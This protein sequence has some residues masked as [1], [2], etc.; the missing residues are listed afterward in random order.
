[1]QPPESA[2][3]GF[4]TLPHPSMT[5]PKLRLTQ[6]LA[7]FLSMGSA[8][9]PALSPA[10]ALTQEGLAGLPDLPSAHTLK[11]GEMSFSLSAQGHA[12]QGLIRDS[13]F[14]FHLPGDPAP[15]S[16]SITDVQSYGL[17]VN[18]AF[19]LFG[20]VDLGFSL[21]VHGD[22]TSDTQAK[23]LSGQGLGDP[24]IFLKTGVGGPNPGAFDI[25]ALFQGHFAS[26]AKAGFLPKD[27]GFVRFDSNSLETRT[28]SAGGPWGEAGLLSTLNLNRLENPIPLAFHLGASYRALPA[29][30]QSAG[31]K[32]QA[33]LEVAATPNLTFFAAG[34]TMTRLNRLKGIQ[35]LADEWATLTGGISVRSDEGFMLDVGVRKG[36]AKA[37]WAPYGKAKDGGVY[38]Y[39]AKAQPSWSLSVQFG[40]TFAAF[41]TDRDRDGVPDRLD[42]CAD[43]AEDHDG[44]QDTDGCPEPDNDFDSISDLQDQ[45][46]LQAED[47]EGFKDEDGCPDPDNDQDGVLDVDDKCP[48]DAEDRDGFVDFDGCPELDNDEDGVHDNR[49]QCPAQ[50]EDKDGHQDEDGCPDLDNDGDGIPDA[51]DTCPGEPETRNGFNDLDGCPDTQGGQ[52]GSLPTLNRHAV[53]DRVV[54]QGLTYELMPQAYAQLDS[55]ALLLKQYAGLRIEVQAYMDNQGGA[56]AVLRASQARAEAVRSYLML[57]GAAASQITARGYGSANPKYSNSSAKGRLANRRIEVAVISD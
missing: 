27:P 24:S 6:A 16:L 40:W 36:F 11:A 30:I 38:L 48:L 47:H 15:D 45:C 51:K 52:Q 33:G 10:W 7:L 13:R 54:F 29:S 14:Y 4:C 37:P 26:Q 3:T 23:R 57:K 35:D 28:F 5:S 12:D 49:D 1:M 43:E 53:L 42:A 34:Q 18:A 2:Q 56:K 41:D 19:G 44:F 50:A 8:I 25:A 46:P 31:L 17:A 39:E 21:P 20:H 9:G 55:V 22:I 32:A